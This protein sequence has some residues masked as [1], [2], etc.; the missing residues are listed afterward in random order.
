MRAWLFAIFILSAPLLQAQENVKSQKPSFDLAY[1]RSEA[2]S[3]PYVQ[4]AI[5][6]KK[7]VVWKLR[8][9]YQNDQH[10][11][12]T[13]NLFES[14]TQSKT[15]EVVTVDVVGPIDP[16]QGR[17]LGGKLTVSVQ[18]NQTAESPLA[19]LKCEPQ[20]E[21]LVGSIGSSLKQQVIE[22]PAPVASKPKPPVKQAQK[23]PEYLTPEQNLKKIYEQAIP[24]KLQEITVS[25]K[26]CKKIYMRNDEALA[27][28]AKLA[29][30]LNQHKKVKVSLYG[31]VQYKK[32]QQSGPVFWDQENHCS[33]GL[34][35]WRKLMLGRA[36]TVK[37]TLIR[38]GVAEDRIQLFP[39]KDDQMTVEV[40]YR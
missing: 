30:Y 3:H 25:F 10:D 24:E 38:F 35:T 11:T 27:Q 20:K 7:T 19:P 33:A 17:M 16:L 15:V 1:F 14:N 5:Q 23:Q 13:E 34:N 32:S 4:W 26:N 28:I 22:V 21:S 29:K 9:N 37:E 18:A 6:N 39:G 31:N 36:G 40:K 8:Y 2:K 12:Y